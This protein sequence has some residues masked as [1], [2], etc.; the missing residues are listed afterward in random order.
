MQRQQQEGRLLGSFR[1]TQST[2]T[3]F[4]KYNERCEAMEGFSFVSQF[5][6]AG[7]SWQ[8]KE[9]WHH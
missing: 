4:H 9:N 5:G 3:V 7:S 2:C 6:G 8:I 1:M